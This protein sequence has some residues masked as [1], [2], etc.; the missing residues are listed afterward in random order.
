LLWVKLENECAIVREELTY[1]QCLFVGDYLS[2][3]LAAEGV[4]VKV[5]GIELRNTINIFK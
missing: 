1:G 4:A 2:R 3:G 5:S